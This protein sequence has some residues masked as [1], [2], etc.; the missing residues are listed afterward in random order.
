MRRSGLL[1]ALLLLASTVATAQSVPS[2]A[3]WQE[4]DAAPPPPLRTQGL[5]P[6]DMGPGTDLRWGVDP[7]SISIGADR[8]VRYV[9]VALGRGGAVNGLYEGVRCDTGEV[10]VYARHARDGD[11][12]PARP[13]WKSL[14]DGS[15]ATLHSLVIARTGVCLGEAPNDSA[16]QI[17]RDLGQTPDLRFR[18]EAR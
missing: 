18:N 15:S 13:E 6:L 5:I 7:A 3:D 2:A 10:R 12:A 16:R 17:A 14:H 1:L 9:V 4:T 11:W 8:V